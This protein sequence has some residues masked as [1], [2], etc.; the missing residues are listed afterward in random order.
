MSYS[1]NQLHA[2]KSSNTS[3]AL[4]LISRRERAPRSDP[5][6]RYYTACWVSCPPCDHHMQ[7]FG[8]AVA[9]GRR[10]NSMRAGGWSIYRPY[11]KE[12]PF[13]TAFQTHGVL[14]LCTVYAF[15][16]VAKPTGKVSL[17]IMQQVGAGGTVV[18]CVIFAVHEKGCGCRCVSCTAS[19]AVV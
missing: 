10:A 5:M 12:L 6:R 9:R 7:R 18:C 14:F 11:R 15:R 19:T 2:N 17:T 1:I 3:R 8:I 4:L 13:I 16:A